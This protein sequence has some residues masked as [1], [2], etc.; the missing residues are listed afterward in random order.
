MGKVFRKERNVSCGW[1]THKPILASFSSYFKMLSPPD[2]VTKVADNN[3]TAEVLLPLVS[4]RRRSTHC[5]HPV[6]KDSTV[7]W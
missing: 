3:L 1:P 4:L 2:Q 7:H 6:L 5:L